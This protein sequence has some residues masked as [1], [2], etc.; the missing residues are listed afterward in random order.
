MNKQALTLVLVL[1]TICATAATVARA[2]DN[3]PAPP[4][5][6]PKQ[7]YCPV[8][9]AEEIDPEVFN[10]YKS[11][12]IYFCCDRC[13]IKFTRDPEKYEAQLVGTP[14]ATP[15][16]PAGQAEKPHEHGHE[17]PAKPQPD[18]DSAK[19]TEH[20]HDEATG[21]PPGKEHD[22]K[23]HGPGIG[24]RWQKWL[25]GFHPP[26]VNFPIG[27]LTAG[28]LAEVLFMLRR[29]S[30]FD[31]V[32]RFCVAFAVATGIAAGILG[33]LFAGIRVTDSDSLLAIHRWL[34]TGTVLWLVV[35]LWASERARRPEHPD[36]GL[37]RFFLFGGTALVS[38]TGFFG[39]AMVYGF[40]HYFL[41]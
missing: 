36:R 32:A 26:M 20:H 12:R 9:P 8:T 4:S 19:E 31:H 39:G 3:H 2:Q 24:P 38:A 16:P 22:H 41:R 29:R 17:E 30:E 10:D 15:Q 35:L 25:G 18:A 13:K 33:W 14:A 21:Q 7:V 1:A 6:T 34:G 5:E 37:Y 28:A 27:V 23:E 11:W 40:D